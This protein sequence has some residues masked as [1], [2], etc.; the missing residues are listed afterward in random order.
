MVQN[1]ASLRTFGFFFLYQE[2]HYLFGWASS[3][4]D[5]L[6]SFDAII[7]PLL[8]QFRFG[9]SLFEEGFVGLG[10]LLKGKEAI[11]GYAKD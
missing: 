10:F 9:L 5:L 11:P 1:F 2:G 4:I 7:I 3:R 6:F 8:P